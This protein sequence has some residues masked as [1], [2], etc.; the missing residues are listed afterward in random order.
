[1]PGDPEGGEIDDGETYAEETEFDS[2]APKKKTTET[3]ER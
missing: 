2:V 3:N 1:M